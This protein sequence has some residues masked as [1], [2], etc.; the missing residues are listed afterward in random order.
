[1]AWKKSSFF[2]KSYILV[3]ILT[4]FGFIVFCR[5]FSQVIDF[6]QIS[7]SLFAILSLPHQHST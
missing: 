7:N 5:I 4:N 3:L 2:L 1:M 6:D